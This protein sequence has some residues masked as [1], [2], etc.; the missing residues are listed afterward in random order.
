MRNAALTGMHL[1]VL[2]HG[3]DSF[4]IKNNKEDR[5]IY[6]EFHICATLPCPGPTNPATIVRRE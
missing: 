5:M 2:L 1:S 3:T 6:V 4:P